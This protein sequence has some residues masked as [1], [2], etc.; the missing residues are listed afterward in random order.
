[1]P[2]IPLTGGAVVAC[3]V[4][5]IV[6]A[7]LFVV[8][9]RRLPV[10]APGA[11]TIRILHLSDLHLLPRQRRKA[12]W[13]RGLAGLQ[14]DLVVVTG[15]NLGSAGAVPGLLDA[16]KPLLR[17]PGVFVNGSNDYFT[18]RFRSPFVYFRGSTSDDLRSVE[19]PTATMIRGLVS[20]G[21]RDLNNARA[22]L[23]VRGTVISFVGVDDPHIGRDRMPGSNGAKGRVHIGVTHAPYARILSAFRDD[24]V[25]LTFAGHTHGGQVRVPGIGALV[26]NC[27]LDRR[28]AR[29]LSGW[30]G[31][32]PD[33][34][35]GE[36]SMWLHVS[37]G[38]GTSPFAPIRFACRPEA[39]L[40]EVTSREEG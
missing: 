27:D 23:K 25:S 21:W 15:D 35:G 4:W 24:G 9:R 6:E 22:V 28:R 39:I 30:P 38:V 14:P 5:A 33:S 11:E 7:R 10:L 16:L 40:L 3:G 32:R 1:M 19:L 2:W 34:P 31:S 29:G 12:R 13:V 37:A 18:P 17:I 8:R 36:A 20:L 26:T